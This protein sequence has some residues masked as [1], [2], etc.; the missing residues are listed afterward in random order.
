MQTDAKGKWYAVIW[1]GKRTKSLFTG[2]VLHWFQF[3]KDGIVEQLK[4]KFLKPK[5]GSGAK[6][7]DTPAHMPDMS[8]V[9]LSDIISGPHQVVLERGAQCNVPQYE[10]IKKKHFDNVKKN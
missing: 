3:D 10:N 6:L 9:K 2:K 7:E 1:L 4:I 8:M 5:T